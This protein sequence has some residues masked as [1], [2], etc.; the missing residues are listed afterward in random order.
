[1]RKL[2]KQQEKLQASTTRIEKML[3]D[4]QDSS[5]GTSTLTKTTKVPRKLSRELSVRLLNNTHSV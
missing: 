5:F 2:Y 4:L 1:M 3:K